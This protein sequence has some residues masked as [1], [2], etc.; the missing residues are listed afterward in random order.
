MFI[1]RDCLGAHFD[2]HFSYSFGPCE[3]CKKSAMCADCHHSDVQVQESNK[4]MHKDKQESSDQKG[5]E[6]NGY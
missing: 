5:G 1:C 4:R 6:R 2:A 3:D